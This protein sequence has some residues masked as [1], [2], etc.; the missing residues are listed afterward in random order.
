VGGNNMEDMF[1]SLDSLSRGRKKKKK[2]ALN[3]T[4]GE[5][6]TEKER[7]KQATLV[8]KKKKEH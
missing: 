3:S 2:I 7:E 8:E 4:K 5:K 6:N 1:Y